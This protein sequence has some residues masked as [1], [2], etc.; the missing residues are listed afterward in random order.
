MDAKRLQ[1]RVNNRTHNQTFVAIVAPHLSHKVTV[2]VIEK[3]VKTE[4]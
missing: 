2:L 4:I 1:P 3:I